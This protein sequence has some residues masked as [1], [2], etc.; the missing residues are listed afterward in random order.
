M[1]CR[2]KQQ[3]GCGLL[4]CE[5]WA[6]HRVEAIE[7]VVVVKYDGGVA[8]VS[9]KESELG[10]LFIK[11]ARCLGVRLSVV[12]SGIIVCKDG[13]CLVNGRGFH[14]VGEAF[15]YILDERG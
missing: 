4:V 14:S 10:S 5:S 13:G 12:L 2:R 8:F 9:R 11:A 6:V 3:G 7:G 15:H 1:C